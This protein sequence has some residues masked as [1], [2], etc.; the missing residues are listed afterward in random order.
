MACSILSAVVAGVLV[1]AAD[2]GDCATS[3]WGVAYAAE[4][5]RME[6]DAAVVQ[7]AARAESQCGT[8]MESSSRVGHGTHEMIIKAAGGSG[9]V[10]SYYLS[11]NGGVYDESCSKPWVELDFEIMGHLAGPESKIWSNMLRGTC[12]EKAEWITVP[13][14][15][16]AD[17]H[18]YAFELKDDSVSF[19]V[20]GHPYRT[21]KTSGWAADVQATARNNGFQEFI[22]LWGKNSHEAGKMDASKF[23]DALGTL[24]SNPKVPLT[25]SFKRP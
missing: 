14:D 12:Q 3:K 2:A 24:D 15:V 20:D 23:R 13:F 19:L 5:C 25:A 4:L 9:V 8:R 18:T 6:G 16:T 21:V 17:F 10:T 7:C 22:S 1:V 11:N